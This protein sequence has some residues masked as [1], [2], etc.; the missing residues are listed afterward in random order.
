MHSSST[1][2]PPA[3]PNWRSSMAARTAASALRR[4]GATTTP[5]PAARPSALT[6]TG[7]PSSPRASDR[8]RVL[9]RL[10]YAV[11]RRGDPVARHEALRE[12]L[13]A[14]EL[15]R[16]AR[17]AE[18]QPAARREQIDDAAIERQLGTDDGEVDALALGNRQHALRHRRRR[19]RRASR[20]RARRDCRARRRP[21]R[22]PAPRPV[23]HASACSRPPLPTTMSLIVLSGGPINP[24]V[25]ACCGVNAGRATPAQICGERP[26]L[27]CP[28]RK[29]TCDSLTH[30]LGLYGP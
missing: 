6:T 2:R 30:S 28:K 29:A 22:H 3:S 10:A 23:S 17:R 7:K 21:L 12:H 13:A 1:R 9:G 8:M 24:D 26:G 16:R 25:S 27:Y 4:S 20:R 15:R 18:D 19:R 5:F 14:F 11:A